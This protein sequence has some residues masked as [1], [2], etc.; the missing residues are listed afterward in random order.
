MGVVQVEIT[1]LEQEKQNLD[2]CEDHN[3]I[4]KRML[5]AMKTCNE[6]LQNE[7]TSM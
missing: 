5:R 7:S 1:R 4:V 6:K 3:D 2:A